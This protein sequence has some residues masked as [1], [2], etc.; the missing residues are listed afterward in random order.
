MGLKSQLQG[1]ESSKTRVPDRQDRRALR[2][3]HMDW[4]EAYR[5]IEKSMFFKLKY[6]HFGIVCNP[7]EFGL[8]SFWFISIYE[9]GTENYIGIIAEPY[10]QF[11]FFGYEVSSDDE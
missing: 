9:A 5:A 8:N 10:W 11:K 1:G 2:S 3:S 6:R 4:Y 7:Q